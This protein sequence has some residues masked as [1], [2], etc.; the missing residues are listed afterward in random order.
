MDV[1]DNTAAVVVNTTTTQNEVEGQSTSTIE[2]RARESTEPAEHIQEKPQ[3]N[4]LKSVTADPHEL[5][6]DGEEERTMSYMRTLDQIGTYFHSC[7][8]IFV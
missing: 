4:A 7:T 3:M 2:W 8:A 5:S 6:S 1:P